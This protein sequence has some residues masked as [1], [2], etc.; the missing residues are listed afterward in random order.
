MR[1]FLSTTLLVAA[2]AACAAP[3]DRPPRTFADCVQDAH[4][5]GPYTRLPL[6]ADLA[7]ELGGR[8]V[9]TGR[10]VLDPGS[11]RTRIESAEGIWVFDGVSAWTTSADTDRAVGPCVETW[12]RFLTAPWRLHDPSATV[13]EVRYRTLGD[14]LVRSAK[15]TLGTD[16]A[17]EDRFVVYTDPVSGRIGAL[18]S[19]NRGDVTAREAASTCA[20]YDSVTIVEDLV[21]PTRLSFWNWEIAR[22]MVGEPVGCAVLS[23][24]GFAAVPDSTFDRPAGSVADGPGR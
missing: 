23:N 18:A 24:Y 4:G 5:A 12:S 14:G 19:L 9:L 3:P 15:L 17:D 11:G 7:V 13:N 6:H 1:A 8:E 22:G 21:L 2:S 20:T 16:E 10:M